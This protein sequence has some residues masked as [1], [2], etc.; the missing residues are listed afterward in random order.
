MAG[1]L[2]WGHLERR[3]CARSG[4]F[5]VK[6]S[7][8]QNTRKGLMTVKLSVKPPCKSYKSFFVIIQVSSAPGT[9][10]H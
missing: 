2:F 5:V 4:H 10:C 3:L 1:G 7:H 8:N 9:Y 6:R